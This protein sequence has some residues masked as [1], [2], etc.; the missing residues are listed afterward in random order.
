MAPET[1][2]DN[3]STIMSDRWSF[4]VLL[5]EIYSI[6]I[7]PYAGMANHEIAGHIRAGRRLEQP[8]LCPNSVYALMLQCWSATPADRPVFSNLAVHL[9]G[10]ALGARVP[11][12]A[13]G[14]TPA[15]VSDFGNSSSA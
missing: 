15:D 9:H 5:W 3:V 8:Q 4:G 1:L 10:E 7:R 13:G 11:A 6:A 14:V 2:D 12:A